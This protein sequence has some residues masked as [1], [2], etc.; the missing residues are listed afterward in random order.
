MTRFDTTSDVGAT[1]ERDQ[2]DAGLVGDHDQTLDF[3]G[4]LGPH[5][6]IRRYLCKAAAHA[7]QIAEALAIGVLQSIE[8]IAA[9]VRELL[10]E[11][12]AHAWFWEFHR[13]ESDGRRR[14]PLAHITKPLLDKGPKVGVVFHAELLVLG[15]PAPPLHGCDSASRRTAAS[16]SCVN[17]E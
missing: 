4:R 12:L 6:E 15:A 8:V 1:A 11:R 5:N 10:G 14:H 3:F 17:A 9:R 7:I 13:V 16:T 2:H